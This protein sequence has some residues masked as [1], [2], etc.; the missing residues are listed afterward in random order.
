MIHKASG[1]TIRNAV[2]AVRKHLN[3]SLKNTRVV[4]KDEMGNGVWRI[5]LANH[6]VVEVT[7][8][9]NSSAQYKGTIK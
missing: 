6:H 5:T 3:W 8:I 1:N 9:R 2:S 4:L 7:I